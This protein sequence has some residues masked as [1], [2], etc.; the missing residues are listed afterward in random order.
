LKVI[1]ELDHLKKGT[2]EIAYSARQV[3]REI[4]SL[5]EDGDISKGV[6]LPEAGMLMIGPDLGPQNADQQV[7]DT[8]FTMKEHG[9]GALDVVVVSKDTTVRIKASCKGLKN[10]DYKSDK[11]SIFQKYGNVQEGDYRNGIESA[12]YVAQDTFVYR[13]TGAFD[14]REVRRGKAA[15]SIFPKNVEQ[16]CAIDALLSPEIG[17]VALT[18]PAGTG[19]LSS[20]SPRASTKRPRSILSTSRFS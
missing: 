13:I 12:R 19:R 6:S 17:I 9:R 8:A 7:V 18:G 5:R 1:E 4:D 11:T 3:L 14:K 2:G 20:P 16:E 15:G 10:E